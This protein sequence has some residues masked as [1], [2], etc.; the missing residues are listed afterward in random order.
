VAAGAAAPAASEGGLVAMIIALLG[1]AFVAMR[2][3]RA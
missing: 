3:R 1:A 2:M